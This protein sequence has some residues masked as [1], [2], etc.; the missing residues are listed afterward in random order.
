MG[1]PAAATRFLIWGASGHGKVVADLVR[2][3]DHEV[4]GYFDRDAARVGTAADRV[5]T[6]VLATEAQALQDATLPFGATAIAL[7]IGANG[8]RARAFARL[9]G[10]PVPAL[11]HP[12]ASVSASASIGRG[13]IVLAGAIV[14]ADALVHDAVIVNSGAIVEHDCVVGTAAHISPNAVLAGGVHVGAETWVGAMAVVI[15]GVRIGAR[16]MIGAGAVVLRDVPDGV[17]VVGN[18]ARELHR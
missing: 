3:L 1:S 4:I 11:A 16:C 2:S 14:N 12:C 10:W 15:Q 17:T 18:P 13:T 9:G 6:R 8:A 5:G 7:G